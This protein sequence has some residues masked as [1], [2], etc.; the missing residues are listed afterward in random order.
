MMFALLLALGASSLD[1][2]ASETARHARRFEDRSVAIAAGYRRIGTDFPGMGEHWVLPAALL[3]ASLD[4]TRPTLLAY[5]TLRGTPTLIGVGFITT[6][7]AQ[8]TAAELPGWPDAWHEHSGLLEEESGAR[9]HSQ[10]SSAN[11]TRVWVLHIW[12]HLANPIDPYAPDNWALPFARGGL[13]APADLDADVGR[14]ASLAV[15]GDAFL[16]ALLAHAGACVGDRRIAC[17]V[18]IARATAEARV[19]FAEARS[20][21]DGLVTPRDAARLRGIWHSME[22]SLRGAAGEGIA[23][24]L[25]PPHPRRQHH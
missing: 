7:K 11:G 22:Q 20:R 25:A 12:T 5:A 23:M 4:A 17:E 15:G 21:T 24:L 18:A 10:P 2:L 6:T 1:S 13:A 16:S 8:T 14:S 3:A 19:V 9:H